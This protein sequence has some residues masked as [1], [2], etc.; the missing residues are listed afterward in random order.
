M[1]QIKTNTKYDNKEN[2]VVRKNIETTNESTT[3]VIQSI[4]QTA[5]GNQISFYYF[6]LVVYNSFQSII[7]ANA[8][9]DFMSIAFT[10][11][12]DYEQKLYETPYILMDF[13]PGLTLKSILN[14]CKENYRM[15]KP[16]YLYTILVG[17][18]KGL[19]D[20]HAGGRVHRDILPMSILIDPDF[21]PHLGNLAD[22]SDKAE[23]YRMH[24]SERYLPPEAASTSDKISI[25]D[26]YDVFTFGSTLF[27]I[28]T[29]YEPF[30]G[31]TYNNPLHEAIA[32]GQYDKRIDLIADNDDDQMQ[33]LARL[34]K[35][36]WEYQ[37]E[38]RP[39]MNEI[40]KCLF[41]AAKNVLTDEEYRYLSDY[42][43]LIQPG[44]VPSEYAQ[45]SE[46]QINKAIENGFLGVAQDHVDLNMCFVKQEIIPQEKLDSEDSYRDIFLENFTELKI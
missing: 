44:N 2:M 18:A 10:Y 43:S 34:V 27:E 22:S 9:R 7:N 25:S 41:D 26:K 15:L 4:T 33:P 28:L 5:D 39:T 11:I 23:T 36:C 1:S 17:I 12:F 19:R 35:K 16:I 45:G 31:T 21:H 30:E 37:Q 38:D 6:T 3:Y 20:L 40:L 14:I 29:Q 24:G 46:Y 13:I 8:I 32:L 42:Y